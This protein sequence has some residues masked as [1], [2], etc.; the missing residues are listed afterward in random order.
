MEQEN[1]SRQES[2]RQRGRNNEGRGLRG[3]RRCNDCVRKAFDGAHAVRGVWKVHRIYRRSHRVMM[4]KA[5]DNKQKTEIV[6]HSAAV[7]HKVND[8]KNCMKTNDKRHPPCTTTDGTAR[9]RPLLTINK[10]AP[11]CTTDCTAVRRHLLRRSIRAHISKINNH[12]ESQ[13]KKSYTRQGGS[14]CE[15]YGRAKGKRRNNKR[16][17]V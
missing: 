12:K 4:M 2:E 6:Q 17:R 10:S 11:P 3:A 14:Q 7:P 8:N 5:L 16:R 15:R 13:K 9:Q 1:G